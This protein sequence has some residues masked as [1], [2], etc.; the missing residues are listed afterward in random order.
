MPVYEYVCT[1]CGHPVEVMHSFTA[2]GPDELRAMR[3]ADAQGAL[4]A[5]H[6]V[7]GLGLGE[8]GPPRQGPRLDQAER[9]PDRRRADGDHGGHTG[10]RGATVPP[11]PRRVGRPPSPA[12][13]D[14]GEPRHPPPS[15]TTP[16]SARQRHP[17]RP[18]TSTSSSGSAGELRLTE[19]DRRGRAPGARLMA[20]P[21]LSVR[22]RLG[23]IERRARRFPPIRG[24]MTI[25]DAYNAVGGGL[26]ASGLAFS[27]LFAVIPGMLLIISVLILVAADADTQ[28]R[29]I[30]WI[31]TQLPPLAGVAAEIVERRQGHRAGG[32]RH[33]PGGLR[34]GRQRLL[35][36]ARECP[37]QVLPIPTRSRSH[38]GSPAQRGGG[39]AGR[40]GRAGGVHA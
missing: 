16:S 3:L 21:G 13:I 28:Q 40:G 5:R 10:P 6:R 39:A 2:S 31:E 34:V 29:F 17:R 24:L 35:P 11:H 30:D 33:R 37:R 9:H 19:T 7:Q 18:T 36:G 8:E 12:S 20:R 27:A 14:G 1:V 26:L 23:A 4:H 22:E 25:N 32:H 38:P 15:A